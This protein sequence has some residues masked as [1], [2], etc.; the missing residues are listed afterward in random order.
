LSEFGDATLL[1]LSDDTELLRVLDPPDDASHARVRAL[2]GAMY[3]MPYAEIHEVEAVTVRRSELARP[4]FPPRENQGDLT[5][6]TPAYVR[7][8]FRFEEIDRLSPFWI[9]LA[10]ELDVTLVV[11]FDPGE[12]ESIMARPV[13]DFTTLAQFRAHFAFID[14][15]DFMARH[16]LTTVE[17]LRDAFDYLKLEVRTRAPAAFDPGD[18]ANRITFRLNV[19]LLFRDALEVGDALRAA[20]LARA[21]L[22]RTVTAP[23]DTDQLSTRRAFVPVVVFPASVVTDASVTEA[24]VQALFA[25]EGVMAV[26]RT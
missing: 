19:A 8:D 17:E 10:A 18:E 1:A 5:R 13:D 25:H 26:F 24:Q 20:K 22:E 6:T 4:A 3:D 9:D 16:G 14:L 7:T 15:D 2:V 12:V 11:E 23:R 21:V